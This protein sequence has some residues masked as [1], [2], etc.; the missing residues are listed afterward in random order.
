MEKKQEEESA[1]AECTHH[2]NNV[3][4]GFIE[5]VDDELL[6]TNQFFP[7]KVGGKPV[8]LDLQGIPSAASLTCKNC[9]N[10]MQ[11]LIQL[12]CPV[13]GESA[14][15][16]R[17]IYIFCCRDGQCH[18]RSAQ[19]CFL[20]FRSQLPR[21]NSFYSSQPP[22]RQNPQNSYDN[23][24]LTKWCS[25]CS[26]CGIPSEKKCAK[27]GTPYCCRQH[28]VFD[29]K[30][31]HRENCTSAAKTPIFASNDYLFPQYDV[32]I[33]DD[34]EDN[35]NDDADSKSDHPTDS[36]LTGEN[37]HDYI[38]SDLA[39]QITE[40]DIKSVEDHNHDEEFLEF[41]EKI[42]LQP[43]QILRYK[44]NG[45]PLWISSK[46]IPSSSDIP[47]CSCGA[48]RIF[49]FQIMPQLLHYLKI[50]NS[51]TSIDWGILLVYTCSKNCLHNNNDKSSNGYMK[52][53]LWRQN[54]S[55]A[56]TKS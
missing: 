42:R 2:D 44:R 54:Y 47:G 40:A 10:V 11:F 12:Y 6:L 4:L 26:L 15:F 7:S 56:E 25:L 18:Q 41:K 32:C 13:D 30:H 22:D 5:E 17:T 39:N 3:E 19:D 29:W 16:H 49:E 50:E 55:S 36:K 20:V 28:Q 27:C 21:N 53:F 1:K 14:C 24:L 35:D 48:K 9:G 51:Q 8:W 31:G 23:S 45:I 37:Y 34:D 38:K 46:D 43:D 52:E 33:D